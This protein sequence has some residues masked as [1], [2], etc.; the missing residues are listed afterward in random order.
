MPYYSVI[1]PILNEAE[2]L[3]ELHRELVAALSA[4]ERPFEIIYVDDGS[5][6]DSAAILERLGG[7]LPHISL[8]R[9]VRNFGK[10]AAYMAGFNFARGEIVLTLDGDLQDDPGQIPLL[11]G[12]LNEGYDL[13]I[14]YKQG[15][16]K[17]ELQK[18]I[19]SRVYNF[20][21][22]K[23]FDL[24]LRDSNSGF[25][26]MRREVAKSLYLYGDRYRFI[27]ELAHYRGFRVG[28]VGVQHRARRHG[29]SK[30]GMTRFWT[31][32]L[33]LLSVRF[34]VTFSRKPLHFFGTMGLIPLL[35]GVGLEFYVLAQKLLGSTFQQ[36]VAAIIIGALLI[37]V[38]VQL[39]ATGLVCE[40]IFGTERRRTYIISST[41][42]IEQAR[43]PEN[44]S[45]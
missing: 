44:F 2:S 33:D 38:S 25:R 26:V 11:L 20:I 16:H 8:V 39:L 17:N 4:L 6:D 34:L 31:G 45:A 30:Y 37:M 15:R 32:L 18:T 24:D 12:K 36:H 3:E 41:M 5:T 22:N 29:V 14:G 27:P 43:G 1:V 40:M 19:P 23:L 7:E 21:K 10:S 35:L 28:E 9:F 13:V 42:G